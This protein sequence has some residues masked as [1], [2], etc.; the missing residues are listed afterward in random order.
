M[1]LQWR[2]RLP[3]R[4]G[5]LMGL[6]RTPIK[7]GMQ[8]MTGFGRGEAAGSG[9]SVVV[10]MKSVN[11]RFL[12][13]Q[14]RVPREYMAFEA[15]IKA[16]LKPMFSRGRL[17]IFVR[18]V[19]QA[20]NVG[21]AVDTQLARSY[22][23]SL[24]QLGEALPGVNN[25]IT[26]SRLAEMPGVMT[27]VD[28]EVDVGGEWG[29]VEAAVSAAAAHLA[30][31]R[32]REGKALEDAL[33]ELI[34]DLGDHRQ[35]V[36][37]ESEGLNA[38]LR[39]KLMDR[40]SRLVSDRVDPERLAQEAALLADKAD[41]TEELTR[42]ASHNKQFSMAMERREPIGRRLDFLA[43]EMN[44]EINT[45]GSKASEH[46]VSGLVVEMKSTLERVREQIANVE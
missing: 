4:T 14:L 25:D 28:H 21:I 36:E 26:L 2:E 17:D 16:I 6:R 18:R 34:V 15:R 45:I 41:V 44:R 33:T 29:V 27:T 3:R 8:S 19:T 35:K 37:M 31:M 46:A 9:V 5:T 7:K 24:L 40:I 23:S 12:D 43:Q 39:I 11:N 13:L 10:E 42:L 38:R 22:H 1:G 20:G 32:T 30:E